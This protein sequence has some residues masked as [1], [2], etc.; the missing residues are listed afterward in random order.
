[1][2]IIFSILILSNKASGSLFLWTAVYKRQQ[3]I[4]KV[5]VSAGLNI[6]LNSSYHWQVK[7]NDG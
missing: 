5:N 6:P 7:D 3:N 4:K 2:R 1:M